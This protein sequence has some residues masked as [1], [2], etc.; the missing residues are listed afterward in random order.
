MKYALV[1]YAE[2]GYAEALPAAEREAAYAEYSA[3]TDDAGYVA[4]AGWASA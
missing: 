4:V 3:L 1:I 2:P